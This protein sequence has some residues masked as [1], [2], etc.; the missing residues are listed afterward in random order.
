MSIL[1]EGDI[2][3]MAIY[4]FR[5]QIIKRNEGRSA[6]AAAA[7]RSADKI[8]SVYEGKDY[9]FTNKRF[10][11]YS[12]ISLPDN[13]PEIYNDR[14]TL[15]NSV[16]MLEKAKDA[17][18]AREFEISLPVELTVE[19]NIQ[20]A[21]KFID[22]VFVSEGMIADWSLHNPARKDDLGRCLD[23]NGN[24]TTDENEYIFS[25]PHIH[26]MT[27]LRPLNDD[28]SFANKTEIE[29]KCIKD[30]KER[31]FTAE[32]F[33]TAKEDGWQKQYRFFD[34]NNKK[35]WLTDTD[36]VMRGL[37]RVNKYPKTTNGG[38]K[39]P[40]VEVWNGKDTLKRWRKDWEEYVNAKFIELGIN[41]RIDSRS[42]KEQERTEEI[43]KFYMGREAYN[44][45]KKLQRLEREGKK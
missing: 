42:F 45:E 10:V 19:Q 12:E 36:G 35:V 37:K 7:Y 21:K 11:E 18:L 26:V 16:E 43:P 44:Y 27:T 40:V 22:E 1:G 6:V 29:Y 31:G 20:F 38:R 3:V 33:K 30:G 32:E 14:A 15:W 2:N 39:N 9:D 4:H 17:Q 34:E 28:G 13:A 24:V 25:N 23:K 5:V 8:K 41:A